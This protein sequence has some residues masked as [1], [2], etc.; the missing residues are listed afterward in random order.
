MLIS[1]DPDIQGKTLSEQELQYLRDLDP[2]QASHSSDDPELTE[3][4]VQ[5][6]KN[7]KPGN[8]KLLRNN[9]A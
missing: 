4:L 5:R 8:G 7:S 9:I 3:E 6:M 2:T 1:Y